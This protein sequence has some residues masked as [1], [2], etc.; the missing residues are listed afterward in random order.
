MIKFNS[1][2]LAIFV[3][4]IAASGFAQ[5]E[6]VPV[7]PNITIG[8]LS[9]GIKYYILPNKKP[10]KRAELR[11]MVNAGSILEDDNQ[12]GL[13]HFVEHMAFNGSTHFKKNEL[14]DF[15]ELIGVKFGPELNAYTS[16]D[17]TVYMLQVPTDKP[18]LVDKGFLVLEDWAHGLS[19][20]NTE[21]DKER[22]VIT[23][24][25][26][27]GRGAG[28]RMLDKQLP[29]I[30]KNSKYADRLT[31]GDVN[32]IKNFEY[33]TLK[34][35]YKDWYRPD[36]M[37]V[38][39][40][41]DFDKAE[42]EK[43]IKQHFENIKPIEKPRVRE[44]SPVPNHKETLFA[45][46]SDKEATMSEISL[47]IKR[48]TEKVVTID[49]Y[50]KSI[51]SSLFSTMINARL[52]ELTLLADP[53]FVGAA[54]GKSGFVR[55]SDAFYLGAGVKDG[56]I[57]KGLEAVLREAERARKFGFT[58]TE[59]DR[60]K[61][62]VLR[63]MEKALAEKDKMESSNHIDRMVSHFLRGVVMPGVEIQ[64]GLYNKL[65]P[66]IT[67]ED[68][69]KMT[70]E[71]LLTDNRVVTVSVP[72]KEGVKI[73]TEESLKAVLDKVQSEKIEAYVDKVKS[74]P[75]VKELPKPGTIV[76]ESKNEKLDFTEWK[77]SNGARIVLKKTDFKNDEIL[78]S[79]FS[80]GGL[81]LVEDNEFLSASMANQIAAESGLGEFDQTE[82]RKALTGK[83]A[84]VN[85]FIGRTHEGFNGSCS[86]AD[87]ETMFQLIYLRFTN[88]RFDSTAFVSLKAKMKAM[89]EN[90]RNEPRAVFDDTLTCTLNNYNFRTRPLT[91]DMLDQI[92]LETAAKKFKE[93]INDAGD[94]TYIFVGNIDIEKMK[95]LIL[96]YIGG[97]PGKNL[98]EKWIDRKYTNPVGIVEKEVRKGIEPKSTVSVIF[99]GD[100][101]WSRTE[102]Y[103]LESLM[104]ALNIR[105][106]EV[107]RE[108]KGGTYGVGIRSNINKFPTP[109]YQ[110]TLGFGCNP[111]RAEELTKAAFMV[112]DSMKQ[113][114]PSNE[115][116]LKVKETQRRT[117]EV[118]LKRNGFWLG[119]F[120][121]YFS[122]Q[123]NPEEFLNYS[124]WNEN[125][126]A[127]DIKATANKYINDKNYIKAI[128]YP[129]AKK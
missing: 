99:T 28:M 70:G 46:A 103:Y 22:G 59:L 47:Y 15:L 58:A 3:L 43:L 74:V 91:I 77:L 107:I 102:E 110:L 87:A 100:F 2:L 24:E 105:L 125:L 127:E 63:G 89:L 60:A 93:R 31:I 78:L 57:E 49:D 72:E 55:T 115:I 41:G 112:L 109:R 66:T 9:N 124:K 33:E 18:D 67:L 104:D 39:A 36:M 95:P 96:Q 14:V 26:R 76:S 17:E 73:P 106:R 19:F 129:E 30:F 81:S 97:L 121:N 116:L 61:K 119:V 118:N 4:L 79:S 6:P 114:G 12:K 126:K 120:N 92:N 16:F 94:F 54:A 10:E 7:N 71:L 83:I 62:N 117:R 23:E 1:K 88:P 53:P 42:I 32:I 37:A 68:V 64:H 69:N 84:N 11:L 90:L 65:V 45:I 25:W 101:T 20:D 122:T 123:E 35:Y 34:K 108:D 75:L 48:P 50:K 82:L 56:G 80:Q 13:A 86:P 8:T 40:V 128:L 27:L 111:D 44:Y 21:I 85:P 5:K 51:I 98:N 52:N 113:F 38:A 29:V